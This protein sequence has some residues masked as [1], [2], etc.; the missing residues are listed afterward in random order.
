MPEGDVI[1]DVA[2]VEVHSI[3]RGRAYTSGDKI[4]G[5]KSQTIWHRLAPF[6]AAIVTTATFAKL[7]VPFYLIGSTPIF[8]VA[9]LIGLSLIVLA[10]RALAE[11]ADSIRDVLIIIALL[12]CAV[13][14]SFLVH[15]FHRVPVT[16]LVGILIFHGVFLLF[17]LAASHSLRAV[18]AVLLAMAAVYLLIV[19]QYTIRFGDLMRDGYLHNVFNVSVPALITTFHQNIGVSLGLSALAGIGLAAGRMRLI[20]FAALPLVFWFL[21]HIAARTAMVA[22]ASSFLFW[23]GAVLWNYS[24]KLAT[25]SLVGIIALIVVAGGL[26]Y[27]R[28]LHDTTVDAVAP[29]A[30]SRT[31]RE[32]QD[33]R[34]LF[35]LQIWTRAIN[36]IVTEPDKLL[37]GHGIG[38]YSI[39]EGFGPPNWLLQPAEGNKYY[40]HN[41]FLEVLYEAGVAGLLPVIALTLLPLWISLS[42][43]NKYS[44]ADQAAILLY[45][46]YFVTV[47]V[48]G[49]FAFSYDFQ[50]FLGLSIGV[51]ALSRM[52]DRDAPSAPIVRL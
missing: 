37:L 39:D 32:I 22:L 45:V 29:D 9:C 42:R 40:P 16:H 41:L 46:F 44:V 23:A 8:V 25:A 21:F 5:M 31:I 24:R 26:F 28:A 51:V 43:W 33:P 20:A 11:Q 38:M 4:Q 3:C 12:Y 47:L 48:S 27:Q 49:G 6:T 2:G 10:G 35:R 36:H 18:F 15:S 1:G 14:A 7:F 19:A 30:I 17:G 34:P 50:F 13:I 52:Q